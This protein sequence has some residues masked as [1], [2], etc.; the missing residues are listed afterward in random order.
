M[1]MRS[2]YTRRNSVRWSAGPTG[3]SFFSAYSAWT[4]ASIGFTLPPVAGGTV[5]TGGRARGFKDQSSG[6][7]SI[8]G[9]TGILGFWAGACAIAPAATVF[10]ADFLTGVTSVL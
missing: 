8:D 4:K 3:V 5:G 10:T 6:K 9:V 2:R 7:S 1:P